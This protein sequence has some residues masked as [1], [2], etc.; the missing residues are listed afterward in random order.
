MLQA[1]NVEVAI[2][3]SRIMHSPPELLEQANITVYALGPQL[4]KSSIIYPLS[5]YADC[6]PSLL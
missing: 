6:V 4:C 3:H 5:A 1:Q 2:Q